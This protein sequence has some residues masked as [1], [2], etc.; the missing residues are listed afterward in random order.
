MTVPLLQ[1][2]RHDTGRTLKAE[3]RLREDRALARTISL[4]DDTPRHDGP[5]PSCRISAQRGLGPY[6]P[7]LHPREPSGDGRGVERPRSTLV[8]VEALLG[9]RRAREHAG[10]ARTEIKDTLLRNG[11][12]AVG[13][14]GDTG[15]PRAQ[16]R[17]LV[18]RGRIL[19][20]V[21]PMVSLDW[22]SVGKNRGGSRPTIKLYLL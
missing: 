10:I 6:L 20:Q 14:Y 9:P 7:W 1:Q 11:F 3:G 21:L 17:P 18:M 22:L 16:W 15:S 2:T 12:E 5:V 4:T 8:G 13:P 19:S